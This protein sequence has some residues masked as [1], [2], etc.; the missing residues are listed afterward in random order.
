MSELDLLNLARAATQDEVTWFTQMITISFA[1]VVAVYYFLHQ[2]DLLT[3]I[4]AF[5]AYLVGML[6]FW[7]EMLIESNLKY[8]TLTALK[9]MPHL[10]PV[11]ENYIGVNGSWLGT[12][13]A[14]VFSASFWVLWGGVF[15]LVFFWK[16]AVLGPDV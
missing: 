5:V 12:T 4:F 3:R 11:T 16:K 1:M 2:A 8:A 14:I 9:A 7:G 10:G 6:T 13:V 15:Y